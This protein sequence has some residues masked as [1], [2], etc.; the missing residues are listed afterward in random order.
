MLCPSAHPQLP[1]FRVQMKSSHGLAAWLVTITIAGLGRLRCASFSFGIRLA[2]GVSGHVHTCM[3]QGL[4]PVYGKTWICHMCVGGKLCL[5]AS[6]QAGNLV[7]AVSQQLT[8]ASVWEN[9]RG[10]QIFLGSCWN[11]AEGFHSLRCLCKTSWANQ[12]CTC[13]E[14]LSS[15]GSCR[16]EVHLKLL[17]FWPL[18]E[19]GKLQYYFLLS[20]RGSAAGTAFNVQSLFSCRSSVSGAI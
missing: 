16:W 4:L 8:G 5:R 17:L 20:R 13:L 19:A 9:V 1:V 11:G 18:L 2:V 15:E 6:W 14:M 7:Q 12:G 10:C 3:L